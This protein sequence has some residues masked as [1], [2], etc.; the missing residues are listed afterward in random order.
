MVINSAWDKIVG[1]A[2]DWEWLTVILSVLNLRIITPTVV[3]VS[4]RCLLVIHYPIAAFVLVNPELFGL[5]DEVRDCLG[6]QVYF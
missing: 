5:G 3:N 2:A 1:G 6:A 4:P